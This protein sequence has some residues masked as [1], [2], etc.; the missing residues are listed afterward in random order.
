VR[1]TLNTD[2]LIVSDLTLSEEYLRVRRRLG[3]TVT[4]LLAL[5]R[6]GYQVAFLSEAERQPLL[7]AF[8]VW[9]EERLAQ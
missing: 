6:T 3:A 5:A 8:D 7:A 1:V 2:D 9:T 4:E